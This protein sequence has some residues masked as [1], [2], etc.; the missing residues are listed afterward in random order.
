M[1]AQIYNAVVNKNILEFTYDGHFRQVEPHTYGVSKKNNDILSAYQ[2]SGGSKDGKVPDWKLFKLDKIIGL[3]ILENKFTS[4]RP[5]Y[6]Q[7]DSR[8]I[9]IYCEL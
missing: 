1:N 2:V 7:N 4:P 5:G 6:S 8:M 3:R 9:K